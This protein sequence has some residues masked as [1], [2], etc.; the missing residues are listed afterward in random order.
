MDV[1]FTVTFAPDMACFV[2]SS[3]TMSLNIVCAAAETSAT[4][5]TARNRKSLVNISDSPK[6][7]GSNMRTCAVTHFGACSRSELLEAEISKYEAREEGAEAD[8]HS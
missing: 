8:C 1:S 7:E 6:F 5:N 2:V 4:N 3:L